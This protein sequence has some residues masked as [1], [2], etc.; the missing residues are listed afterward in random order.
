MPWQIDRIIEVA[1]SVVLDPTLASAVSVFFV[2]LVNEFL[3]IFPLGVIL[4]GQVAFSSKTLS[5]VLI[6]KL[7]LFVAVPVGV[8]VAIGSLFI[9]SIAYLG[10]KPVIDRFGKYL[11]F[12]WKDVERMEKKFKASKYDELLFLGL[13]SMPFFPNVP[14]TAAAGILRMNLVPFLVLTAIGTTLRVM[15]MMFLAWV[16]FSGLF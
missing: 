12:S 3:S 10:G 6:S 4:A 2:A 8:G 16:G 1:Q 5:L 7:F 9:Y 14:V 13:R 11:R 15:L